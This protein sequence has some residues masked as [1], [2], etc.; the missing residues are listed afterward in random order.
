MLY[1]YIRLFF[2]DNGVVTDLSIN[3]QDEATTIPLVMVAAEDY[4]YLAQHMPFNNFFVQMDT[5]N[6]NAS[7]MTISYWGGKSRD[8]V[9]AI[10]IL[11]GTMTGGKTFGRSGVVQFSPDPLYTWQPVNENRGELLPTGL[12]TIK[13]Y[14]VY[15][16][17]I[18]V[19]A[20]LSA[21]TDAKRFI[22]S[23]TRS[24]QLD[25]LDTTIN[26]F[27]GSFATGK[28]DWDDQ[29]VTASVQLVNDLR[30][31][32]L[33][34]S[35]GEILRFDDVT[36]ACDY[37]TLILIY[38]NLGP[39][40]KDKLEQAK[41]DYEDTINLRRFSFDI[42]QDGYLNRAEISSRVKTLER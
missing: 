35:P 36:M 30:R 34:I 4:I 21:L 2:G 26:Q 24:Q 38:K 42:D 11:D 3:N 37:K 17:R 25:N 19:S 20:N 16:V 5:V 13:V 31:R 10:D 7:L 22:Y 8:W 41:L 14:N 9:P 18:K 6:T 27:L 40:Y 29:I 1:N 23:F 32:G 15:W 39:G 33:I 12:E 28:T